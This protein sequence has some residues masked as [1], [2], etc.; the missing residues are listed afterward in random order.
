MQNSANKCIP[1]TGDVA[2]EAIIRAE[3]SAGPIQRVYAELK[4]NPI[5]S[6]MRVFFTL[7]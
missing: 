2:P 6:A 7:S 1:I 3:D 5:T 4:V